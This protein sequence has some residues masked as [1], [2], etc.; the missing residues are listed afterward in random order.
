[1]TPPTLSGEEFY[2]WLHSAHTRLWQDLDVSRIE[3]WKL[4]QMLRFMP[5]AR[6]AMSQLEKAVRAE[7]KARGE[8]AWSFPLKMAAPWEGNEI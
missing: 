8:T 7:L 5:G 1:M 4:D 2:G 6:H 3:S